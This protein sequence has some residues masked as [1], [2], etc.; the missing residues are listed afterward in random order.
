MLLSPSPPGQLQQSTICAR[1]A[2]ALSCLFS[3]PSLALDSAPPASE[4]L[5]TTN[6]IYVSDC[7]SFVGR[8]S[9]GS[10]AFALGNN[11][12]RD[13]DVFQAKHFVALHDEQQGWVEL[14]GNGRYDNARRELAGI[15]DSPAFM[16]QGTPAS[17][18]PIS[19]GVNTL[20][21]TIASIPQYLRRTDGNAVLWM[22]AATAVLHW[23]ERAIAGRAI[24][25]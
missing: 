12:G 16:F 24:Y 5:P 20:R 7:F 6:L 9:H 11:R 22:G 13:G 19:S 1:I 15:P 4:A 14:T 10:V 21:F 3:I 8:D 17:G 23:R 25:E 2:F 18:M